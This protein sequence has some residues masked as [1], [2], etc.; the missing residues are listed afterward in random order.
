MISLSLIRRIAAATFGVRFVPLAVLVIAAL[1]WDGRSQASA[2]QTLIRIFPVSA[3]SFAPQTPMAPDSIAAIFLDGD[4]VPPGTVV[5]GNDT[6][7][8][9]P[10]IE[11]PTLLQNLTVEVHGRSA[12]IFFLSAR[13]WNILL[14]ADLLPGAGPIV[15]KD[16]TGLV[17]AAGEI[18]IA[19]VAPAIFTANTNGEGAPA[20]YLLRFF[21][22][23]QSVEEPVVSFDQ[24]T[25]SFVPQ[26]ITLERSDEFLFL[27]LF[28]T[29][30]RGI[31]GADETRLLL[32]GV[33]YIPDFVGPSSFLGVE[34]INFRLP[35]SLPTGVSQLTFIALRDGRA[36][37]A[38][39]IEVAPP[40]GSPPVIN[41]LNRAESLAGESLEITGTGFTP[42]TEVLIADATRRTHNAKLMESGATNMRVMVPFG[43]GSGSLIVRNARG[44]ASFPFRMR[45][46][47]SGIVQRVAPGQGGSEERI[48]I[49]NVTIRIRQ[50]NIERTTMTNDDGS[51]ILPD[52]TPTARLVFEVDGT[53]NGLLPFPKDVRS[54]PVMTGRDNQYEGYIELKEITGPSSFAGSNGVMTN[55]LVAPVR[56]RDEAAQPS[57][58]VFDP[59]GSVVRFPDGTVL[60]D[61]TATALDPGRVPANLPPSQ[62]SSTIVQLTPFGATLDP[63]GKLTF[64]NTDGYAANEVVTLY[65][66]DQVAGSNT[67]GE[68]V[69]AGQA[70][71]TAD[72]LR[73]ETASNAIKE[74]TY[75]FVSKPRRITTIYGKVVEEISGGAEQPARGALV[76]VRG[77]S[78]FSLTDQSGTYTLRNV[79]IPDAATLAAGFVIEVSFLR[80]DG[81]VDRADREGVIPGLAGLTLVTPPIKVINR[82]RSTAPVIQ[83]PKSL[84]VEAGRQSEFAFLAYARVAER[85]LTSVQVQGAEFASVS[86]LGNERYVLRLAPPAAMTGTFTLEL[87][88]TDSR[89]ETTSETVLVEVRAGQQQTPTAFSL[90]VETN[91]DQ[92]VGVGLMG[93][94][95]DRFRIV[96]EPR[97]GRLSGMMPNLVYTPDPDFNGADAFSFVVGNGTVESAPA[98]VTINVRP[99]SDAP[100]LTVGDRFTTNIGQQLGII[101]NGYDGDA[102]Q[103]LKLVGLGLPAGALIRQTSATSWVL[104]WRPTSAQIGSYTVNLILSDD[105][106]PVLNAEKTIVIVVEA[107]WS[108]G[109]TIGDASTI[110]A[111]AALDDL[112]FAGTE[113]SGVYRSVDQGVT[114]IE[115]NNRL[116]GGGARDAAALLASGGVLFAG[117]SEG[118]FRSVDQ[119]GSWSSANIGLPSGNARLVNALLSAG[120]FI[121]AGTGA[122]V[123]RSNDNGA[124]WSAASNGLPTGNARSVLSLAAG[125]GVVFAGTFGGGVYRSTDNGGNWI[126]ANNGLP[127]GG[128]RTVL[129]LMTSGT[130]IFA[131]TLFQGIYRSTDQGATWVESNTGLPPGDAR[132]VN[133]LAAR[134][135]ALFAGTDGG[136]VYRSSDD[137]AMW[138]EANTGLPVGDARLVRALLPASA[139]LFAGTRAGIHRTADDGAMWTEA[140]SGLPTGDSRFVLSL[141]T[142]GGN[143]FA[144]TLGAGV[145]RSTDDGATWV[146]VNQGLPE[147]ARVVNA[148]AA[149]SETIFAGTLLEGIYRSADQGATW[150]EANQGLPAGDARFITALTV[151]TETV[152]AGTFN[153]G[154]YRSMNNGAMWSEANTGLP[155]G[156]ARLV[157][158]LAASGTT[159]FAGTAAGVYRSTD[160]GATWSESNT[161]LPAGEARQVLSLAAGSSAVFAGTA[162]GIYRST[163]N[164]ATWVEANQGLSTGG[165]PIVLSLTVRDQVIFAGT[166]ERGVFRSLDNGANWTEA[167]NGLA[168]G[169]ART[170]RALAVRG[171]VVL[172]GTQGAGAFALAESA[173]VWERRNNGLSSL[174]INAAA[175]D[176]EAV[177]VGT[178]GGGVFRT[179]DNG[180]SWITVN[181]GL[182]PN[183]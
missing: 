46:S 122:G 62:F 161:G 180:L 124:T 44:E 74:T 164:G 160:N 16:A 84:T 76:Q 14:P 7:P 17:R 181:A 34:Q 25:G 145:Y 118:I 166:L 137:G 121:F 138:T 129:S 172:A 163:D 134:G 165:L 5:I 70:Q 26:P 144:G 11:L 152:F 102:E 158:S 30:A 56:G 183:A 24:T 66:F 2:A 140:S 38:C 61:V 143:S 132:I 141:T 119:G 93:S 88:A 139:T 86:G 13:Q 4:V 155:A 131:G 9:T 8:S 136:G 178:F 106:V 15:I 40:A 105:G 157:S 182:P 83:A 111:L 81:T 174:T 71:V 72:A 123:F 20:A 107:S 97:R 117:T 154:I 60:N 135:G 108:P 148:L 39:E 104:E 153:V 10:E 55:E 69:A 53:T 113:G 1:C 68:F 23:G 37:N 179:F 150:A 146:E 58:V 171:S 92:A 64:P 73:V 99:V 65:R 50:N 49:R 80:P 109:L 79:P 31:T 63:G 133:T 120:S 41:A 22:T 3:A 82:G 142:S 87:R 27:I 168:A 33:E 126:E 52:V 47:M 28:L 48:G 95:G 149:S 112:L 169:D 54:L 12:G 115:A 116:P 91:E 101:I 19:P 173:V 35:R 130:T 45:T 96:G 57:P 6:N 85:T 147:A 98:E 21:P 42:D 177:L 114:W 167:N 29:G 128:A 100:I 159:V 90:S 75:Y 176:G 127:P 151:N 32:G 162:A 110:R 67:L 43:S 175:V 94:G 59:Q 77:Q 103:M 36:A 78:I 89:G 156:A 125:G 18:E 170:V 51:F